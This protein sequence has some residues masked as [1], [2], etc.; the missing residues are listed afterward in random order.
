MDW[1]GDPSAVLD[2]LVVFGPARHDVIE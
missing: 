2:A 1:V